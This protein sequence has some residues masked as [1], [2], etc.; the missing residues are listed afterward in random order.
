MVIWINVDATSHH[1]WVIRQNLAKLACFFF[2]DGMIWSLYHQKQD[3][4]LILQRSACH[5]LANHW[6]DQQQ[7]RGDM[8]KERYCRLHLWQS[9]LQASELS[10][11]LLFQSLLEEGRRWQALWY[12]NRGKEQRIPKQWE[13]PEGAICSALLRYAS[14]FVFHPSILSV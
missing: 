2:A 6:V 3:S 8:S 11:L 14:L 13:G 5:H 4:R 9:Q 10:F 12:T 1:C 7:E